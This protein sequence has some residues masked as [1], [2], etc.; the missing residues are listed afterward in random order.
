MRRQSLNLPNTISI[1]EP[2]S[3][4]R[5]VAQKGFCPGVLT[6][7]PNGNKEVPRPPFTITVGMQQ[8][9]QTAFGSANQ[10]SAFPF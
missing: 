7:L 2:P 9:V 6:N 5:K 4:I 10:A 3:D 8:G 1:S